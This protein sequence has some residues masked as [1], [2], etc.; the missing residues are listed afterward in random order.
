MK[1]H[2]ASMRWLTAI[3]LAFAATLASAQSFGDLKKVLNTAREKTNQVKAAAGRAKGSAAADSPA[4]HSD[5]RIML[6]AERMSN[7]SENPLH[8]EV[9]INGTTVDIF[10]SDKFEP[11]EKYLQEGWNTVTVTTTPQEPSNAENS[12]IFRIG[13]AYRHPQEKKLAMKPVLWEFR[14]GTD[15]TMREDGTW[16]HARG[17]KV[18]QVEL[19]FQFYFAGLTAEMRELDEGD[20]V[21]MADPRSNGRNPSVSGTIFVNGTPLN[22]FF[23]P[24]RQVV[25][26]PYLKKGKNEIRIVSAR[27]K[28]GVQENDLEF[29]IAG[30]ARWNASEEKYELKPLL[31]FR[32]MQGWVRDGMSGQLLNRTDPQSDTI[33]RVI[34]LLL[35]DSDQAGG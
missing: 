21:L 30:P 31:Q 8:S 2:T 34:P 33:E 1:V 14:N 24:Q 7:G 10:T 18:K 3:A 6:W 20:L 27:V 13:P 32:G 17:P 29:V 11:I 5:G 4:Q 12:L 22:T 28:N 26:T 35:K 16:R 15:W 25:I 23:Q 19:S 9:A